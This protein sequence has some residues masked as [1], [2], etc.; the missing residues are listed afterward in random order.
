LTPAILFA[1]NAFILAYCA[2][3]SR[4]GDWMFLW[5]LEPFVLAAAIV[6]PRQIRKSGNRVRAGLAAMSFTGLMVILAGIT[7]ST[8]VLIRLLQNLFTL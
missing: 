1:G 3:T 5:M 2:L 6:I 8:S 4:W 7:I